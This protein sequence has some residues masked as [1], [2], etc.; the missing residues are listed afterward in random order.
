MNYFLR[1]LLI[2]LSFYCPAK[3]MLARGEQPPSQPVFN[4]TALPGDVQRI[5]QMMLLKNI[6]Q[7]GLG[8]SLQNLDQFARISKSFHSFINNPRNTKI[9]VMEMGRCIKGKNE[10][11]IALGL[12]NMPGI[13]SKEIQQWIKQ[14]E[15]EIPLEEKL[16]WNDDCD[17]LDQLIAQGVD[18]NARSNKDGI[19]PFMHSVRRNVRKQE[20]PYV[21]KL[22]Q[23]G[24]SADLPCKNG[25]TP[26]IEA[27]RHGRSVECIQEILKHI[28]NLDHKDEDGLTALMH[29]LWQ[30]DAVRITRELVIAGASITRADNKGKTPLMYAVDLNNF[31][32][33]NML[34][35]S[36][37]PTAIDAQDA[38]GETVLMKSIH[39]HHAWPD[40]AV[41]MVKLFLIENPDLSLRDKKGRT[42]LE[43]ATLI[44]EDIEKEFTVT[45]KEFLYADVII[46]E[47]LAI[48][49]NAIKTSIGLIQDKLNSANPIKN[50]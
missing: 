5:I 4:F 9:L 10:L 43:R 41:E 33:I 24:A 38:D 8:D 35:L 20:L 32:L 47:R 25:R 40:R 17:T 14:R 44:Q 6:P 39:M 46:E 42:A 15:Q 21:Q 2:C 12:K 27:V 36:G 37:K 3:A 29:A 48:K 13:K 22:L 16:R 18:I 49:S 1:I 45:R 50:T 31:N 11:D 19:T 28:K 7:P 26:L 23:L 34:L 30:T